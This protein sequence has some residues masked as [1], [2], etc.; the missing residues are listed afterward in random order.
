M[1]KEG[2]E[3]LKGETFLDSKVLLRG[4][5]TRVSCRCEGVFYTADVLVGQKTQDEL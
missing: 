3:S 1:D 2:E 5:N 4:M